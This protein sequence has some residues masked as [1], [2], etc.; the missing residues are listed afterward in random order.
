MSA[1]ALLEPTAEPRPRVELVPSYITTAAP[2]VLALL[3]M[4]GMPLLPWQTRF[5]SQLFGENDQGKWAA[6]EACLIVPRQNGKSY[7]M[8]ARVLAGLFLLNEDLITYTAHRVDT[9]LEVFN[10]V[11]R[12]ARS[13]PSTARLIKR[14]ARTGGKETLELWDGRRFKILAR[15]RATGRGFTGDCL[16]LDEAIELRDFAP[17]NALLPTLATRPNA[18]LIYASSAGDAGSVVLAGVRDRGHAG[19][20][21]N[22]LMVEYATAKDASPDDERAIMAANPGVP[23][24]IKMT[25]IRKERERMSLEGFRQERMGVWS[26]ELNRAVISAGAWAKTARTVTD[27]PVPGRLGLAF[28][29]ATDRSWATVT[30]A[31][32]TIDQ[33]IHVRVA[34]HDSGD[35]WLLEE[36]VA[37]ADRYKIAISYDDAGPARDIGEAL[38]LKKIAVEGLGGRDFAAACARFVSGLGAELITH[39]PDE[40]LDRAA[41]TAVART[42]GEGW[43]FARRHAAAV[44]ISPVTSAALAVWAVDH[45]PPPRPRFR[46]Y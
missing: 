13:H 30:A 18:Q 46:V 17:I 31:Y 11:D 43:A 27:Q 5:L 1:S 32:K 28:D 6:S 34:R 45:L 23:E 29:V 36:L 9:A 12:L 40:A 10:V 44:P 7:I 3:A 33:R 14:T 42:V 39:H 8:A 25:A 16:I 19:G 20:D 15:A 22:L 26:H 41:E 24:L 35:A 37:L 2:E 4:L 38:R 21:G